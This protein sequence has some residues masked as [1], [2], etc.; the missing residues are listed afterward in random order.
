MRYVYGPVLSRRLGF[1][2]GVSLIEQKT[3][4][5][6]CV[7][8]QLGI[9]TDKTSLRKEY[10]NIESVLSELREF[11]ANQADKPEGNSAVSGNRSYKFPTCDYI[12]ICGFGE[13]T[14]NINIAKLIS[15]IKKIT[16]TPI[17][18]ITNSS[19]FIDSVARQDVLGVDLVVPSLD[20]VTQSIF[21]E[22][23]RPLPGINIEEIIEGLVSLRREFSGKIYLEIMLIKGIN[24]T[25]DYAQKFKDAIL[26][27][28][29]DKIQLNI[30]VRLSAES[31]VEPSEKS[32]LLEIKNILGPKCEII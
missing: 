10:V 14:L 18:L 8:C 26:K 28:N 11:F 1:S 24:D 30:P 21:E 4:S 16:L 32:R 19:L 3:C 22:I 5:F 31:W 12:S 7:Y 17:A 20:A 2:L 6:D 23:D 29:P 13:P 25:L 27:I 9:T 15:E